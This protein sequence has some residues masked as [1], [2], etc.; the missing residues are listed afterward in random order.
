MTFQPGPT[1]GLVV[2][3][4]L[5]ARAV[6]VLGSRG[7]RVPAGQQAFWWV[8]FAL[9]TSAFFSPLDTM[10]EKVIWAHM[11]QHTLMADISV[12]LLMIGVRNPVLQNFLPRSVLVPLAH[13]TKLR[14]LF[15]KARSPKFAIP[16]YTVVLYAWHLGPTF[17]AAL[18]NDF[19]HGLQHQSFIIFSA[20]VWWPLIEPEHR[21]LPAH[22]WKIPYVLG[23]RLPTMFLGMAFIVA[24]TPFYASFY[25]TG[26]R[27]GGLS[28]LSDQQLGGAIMMML[29]VVVL[30]V[31]LTV[32]FFRA[33][34]AEDAD[35]QVRDAA[36]EGHL[37]G[38]D[39][40]PE[41]Q[42]GYEVAQVRQ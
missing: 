3:A 24:Q 28:P 15:R 2:L 13:Q 31:V 26:T 11:A 29:D 9:L 16:I 12:P 18:R 8:G 40:G 23:A 4:L 38:M 25:G 41:V 19:V 35:A 5:Y 22:L 34:S 7:Y 6:R 20:L 32:V 42:P 37:A 17:T 30:M 36:A 1:L 33:A 27:P 14:A 10:A 39:D 21:R